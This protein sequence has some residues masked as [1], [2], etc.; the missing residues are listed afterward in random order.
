MRFRCYLVQVFTQRKECD[1]MYSR[2][3]DKVFSFGRKNNNDRKKPI[4]KVTPHHMAGKLDP[5]RCA[6]MHYNSDGSSANYYIGD[7]GTIVGGVDEQ[8]RAWTSGSEANDTQAI[9]IEVSNSMNG[10]PWKISDKA[11]RSLVRL[12]ADICKRYNIKPDYNG[13]TTGTITIHKM[14][15]N[16]DCPGDYLEKIIKSG[17]FENDVIFEMGG[18]TPTPTPTP[19]PSDLPEYYVV[20]K[21]DTLTKIAKEHDSS[22]NCLKTLN[23]LPN[24]NLIVVGQKLIVTGLHIVQKGDTLSRIAKNYKTTVTKL[25]TINKLDDPNKIYVGQKLKIK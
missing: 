15:Q 4:S 17:K 16:T 22:V 3:V 12:T 8:Y 7:D 13:S 11:Y 19:T 25:A 18:V 20:Q 23:N 2:L 10:E 14:F 5:M 21:G 1:I 9:T 6:Q 24:A